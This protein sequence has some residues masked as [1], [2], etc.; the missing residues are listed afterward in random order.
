MYIHVYAYILIKIQRINPIS[1]NLIKNLI[2]NENGA[3]SYLQHHFYGKYSSKDIVEVVE[4]EVMLW[5]FID[6][7]LG[8][9][10]YTTGT[11]DDHDEQVKVTQ[12]DNKVT[13]ATESER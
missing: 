11:N 9:K 8:R 7:V 1:Q 10:G 4:D 3:E 12:I 2:V 6:R 13:E 5:A